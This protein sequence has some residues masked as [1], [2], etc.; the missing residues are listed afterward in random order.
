MEPVYREI[1]NQLGAEL[2]FHTG[3]I[4]DGKNPL[5][6]VVYQTD[7]VVF[8]TS[9]NS[10]NA[11]REVKTTCKKNGKRFVVLKETGAIS[12]EKTLRHLTFN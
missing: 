4:N 5:R 7:V 1:V 10:H 12:L 2:I 11:L 3:R 9:I 6:N 8:I